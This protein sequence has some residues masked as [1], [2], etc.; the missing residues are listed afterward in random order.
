PRAG[1]PEALPSSFARG[2]T[3]RALKSS[4]FDRSR[5]PLLS[6]ARFRNHVLQEVIRLLSLSRETGT[7]Q[8]QRGRISYAQ[9]GIN[10]LG[11]VYEGLLA[12]SGF[13]ADEALYEV[14]APDATADDEKAQSYFIPE[15]AVKDYR[16]EEFVVEEVAEGQYRR[17]RYERGA[18]VF[19]LAGRDR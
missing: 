13:F 14:R 4:L 18:F 5:R 7:G 11:A 1:G 2:F 19:R 15:S 10:Q 17:K 12:Y 8:K 9:L 6:S 16:D 3:V